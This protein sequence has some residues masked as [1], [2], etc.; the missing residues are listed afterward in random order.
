MIPW[1]TAHK[2]LS[3][4][5]AIDLLTDDDSA[6]VTAALDSLGRTCDATGAEVV[7]NYTTDPRAKVAAAA[8]AALEHYEDRVRARGA[9]GGLAASEETG[10]RGALSQARA[11]G[12]LSKTSAKSDS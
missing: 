5:E 10:T 4:G 9:H 11:P 2:M 12:A 6:V 8:R 7:G 3:Q 1:L